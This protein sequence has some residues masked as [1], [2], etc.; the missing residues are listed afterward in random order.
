M[1]APG[2]DQ[3]AV[4]RTLDGALRSLGERESWLL[5][6]RF[7]LDDGPPI[8]LDRAAGALGLSK[9]RVR[10]IQVRA[11]ET[12]ATGTHAD[13]LHALLEDADDAA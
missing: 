8:T 6:R 10:Q 7:G 9:E 1:A 13:A 4:A 12:L 3:A 5:R 2:T 11:L